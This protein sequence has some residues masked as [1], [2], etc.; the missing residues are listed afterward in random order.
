[1]K[2]LPKNHYI[3]IVDDDPTMQI[4]L[5]NMVKK[6]GY[7]AKVIENIKQFQ[8]TL[9]NDGDKIAALILDRNLPDGD[10]L[11]LLKG[12]KNKP[13]PTIMQSGTTDPQEIKS[14]IEGGAFSFLSKP[15]EIETLDSALET[16][17]AHAALQKSLTTP[18]AIPG[19]LFTS[20]SFT[21]NTAQE[22]TDLTLFLARLFPNPAQ[23][24]TGLHALIQNAISHGTAPAEI[25]FVQKSD[26]NS[27]RITDKGDGFDWKSWKKFDTKR[28]TYA[29]GYGILKAIRDFDEIKYSTAGNK[30]IATL[31]K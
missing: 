10:G 18:E 24:Y 29:D 12:I 22:A 20:A 3:L 19:N 8:E 14:I 7:T 27:I 11:D 13:F 31:Y 23:I 15:Y 9:D 26:R 17:L 30:V 25:E 1:M 21:I 4:I 16:A 6:I 5:A 28:G 2:Q